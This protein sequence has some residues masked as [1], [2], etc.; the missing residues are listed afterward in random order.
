VP[1]VRGIKERRL[2]EGESKVDIGGGALPWRTSIRPRVSPWTQRHRRRQLRRLCLGVTMDG[3]SNA[4]L[5]LDPATER[6]A[7]SRT[8]APLCHGSPATHTGIRR[9]A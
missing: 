3:Y 7:S 2:Q 1:W 5:A 4:S 8:P 6:A 9:A